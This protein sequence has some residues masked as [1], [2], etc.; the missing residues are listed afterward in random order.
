MRRLLAT[1]TLIV[2]LSFPAYA[3]HVQTSGAYCDCNTSG[4][5]PDYPGECGGHRATQAPTDLGSESLLILASLMLWL[6]LRA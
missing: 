1:L 4:C 2:C 3:G 6:R 5:I